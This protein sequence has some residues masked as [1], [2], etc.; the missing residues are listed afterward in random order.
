[1][2]QVIEDGGYVGSGHELESKG[3]CISEP[4]R[5]KKRLGCRDLAITTVNGVE[6]YLWTGDQAVLTDLQAGSHIF[7]T[8]SLGREMKYI[9]GVPIQIPAT[10]DLAVARMCNTVAALKDVKEG[11]LVNLGTVQ[12]MGAHEDVF[13]VADST[14]V[15]RVVFG[16]ACKNS[17]KE[18]E[19]GNWIDLTHV[20]VRERPSNVAGAPAR[21]DIR[22]GAFA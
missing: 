17:T 9:V 13:A 6:R 20:S 10:P 18:V 16:G 22:E 19:V 14:H 15:V 12:V 4:Y 21:T 2:L 11:A 5:S 8:V 3:T 1:M 7:A